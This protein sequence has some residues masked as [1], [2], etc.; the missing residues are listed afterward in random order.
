[1]SKKHYFP[2]NWLQYKNAPDDWFEPHTF[3]EIMHFKL[4][5]WELPSSVCC[6]IR[7][8]NT[9]TK[10]VKEYVYQRESAAMDRISRLKRQDDIDFTVC[11]Q[12]TISF[13]TKDKHEDIFSDESDE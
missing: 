13:V 12:H 9:K 8:T 6:M 5:A 7:V 11:T 4:S 10:K 1:M 3:E 2:H